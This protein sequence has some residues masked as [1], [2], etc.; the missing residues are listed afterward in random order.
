MTMWRNSLSQKD[1]DKLLLDS[2]LSEE[3]RVCLDLCPPGGAIQPS[4]NVAQF[5]EDH[6]DF[7]EYNPPNPLGPPPDEAE[8][9]GEE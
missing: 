8:S 3:V 5:F 9:E 2:K 7:V 6:P 1:H 4:E